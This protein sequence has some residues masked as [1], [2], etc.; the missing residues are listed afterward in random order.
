[1]ANLMDDLVY[2]GKYFTH[3]FKSYLNEKP[4]IF[5]KTD[6]V[7]RMYQLVE[8]AEKQVEKALENGEKEGKD[9]GIEARN[10]IIHAREWYEGLHP[11][12]G[13]Q[14]REKFCRDVPERLN[15]LSDKLINYKIKRNRPSI[16]RKEL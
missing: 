6:D 9:E 13:Q 1:M 8:D 11:K 2:V 4:K 7:E 15:N 16:Q 3:K 14:S 10:K 5:R 12:M